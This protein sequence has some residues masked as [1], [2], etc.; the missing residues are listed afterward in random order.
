M[1]ADEHHLTATAL[2]TEAP[3]TMSATVKTRM[4]YAVPHLMSAAMFSRRVGEIEAKHSGQF[5]F[6]LGRNLGL[7]HGHCVPKCGGARI[8]R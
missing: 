4:N 6:V 8:V 3:D 2:I 1:G 5:W 7:R